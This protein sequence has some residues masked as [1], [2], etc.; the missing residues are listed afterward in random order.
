MARRIE[1]CVPF[2]YAD[3]VREI[4]ESPDKCDLGENSAKPGIIVEIEGRGTT[5]F[6][7]TVPSGAVSGHLEVIR[8]NGLG[9]AVGTVALLSMDALKP[10]FNKGLIIPRKP[11]LLTP[12]KGADGQNVGQSNLQGFRDFQ[13][14]RLTTEEIYNNIL[15]LANMT[16]NT[17][18]NL[19]GASIIAVGGLASNA[20]I[21]IVAAMLVSPI[22]GPILGMTFGYRIADWR[23]FKI[24][25][26]NEI[27]MAATAYIVGAICGLIIGSVGKTYN[28]PTSAMQVWNNVTAF[29]PA[30]NSH[31]I[32]TI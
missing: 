3:V 14:A 9:S 29:S 10:R 1:I 17:W 13:K 7:V 5:I 20:T 12:M 25:V 8:N 18:V 11:G 22:M 4:L 27:K 23:L 6:T 30:P 21:F 26:I 16:I 24:G 28:W 2:E 32:P 31:L 19:I 15:N